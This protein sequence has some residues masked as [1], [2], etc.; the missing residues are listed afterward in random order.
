MHDHTGLTPSSPR[1]RYWTAGSQG[2]KVIFIMGLGMRGDVWKFQIEGLRDT[3]QVAWFDNRGIGESELGSA[4]TWTMADM[5]R[6]TLSVMDAL[7][8]RDAHLVGVS[9]G[10]MVAQETALMAESRF[11]SLTLIAT[12]EGGRLKDKLPSLRGLR[13]FLT[14]NL[15]SG[16]KRVAALRHLLY[17][18]SFLDSVDQAELS[19]RMHAQVGRPA[20]R[21]TANGQLSAVLRHDAGGRLG[22]L[23]LPTLIVRCGKDVLV[24]P[25]RSDRLRRR[26]AHAKLLDLPEAGHGVIFQCKDEVNEGLRRHFADAENTVLAQSTAR[27]H[28]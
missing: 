16:E 24:P 12:M 5:A 18:K 22:Q 20:K 28:A 15:N 3:H 10:G 8:W 23:T 21:A 14:A 17:P 25:H 13:H 1:L 4:K 26:I 11:R 27:V 6:D 7:G 2:P 9:L 19:E